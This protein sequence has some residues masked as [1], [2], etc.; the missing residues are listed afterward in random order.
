MSSG[1]SLD[2]TSIGISTLSANLGLSLDLLADVIRNPA[3][4]P[5]EVD[6]SGAQ[7]LA[8][9]K[10]NFRIRAL[11]QVVSCRRSFG[12]RAHPYAVPGSGSGDMAVVKALTPAQ[13]SAFHDRWLRPEKARIFVV[14]GYDAQ[15]ARSIA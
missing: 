8:G 4:A 14:G 3:F 9:I 10:A 7:Q 13:L 2:R 11:L 15:N 12:A 5:A 1:A 6:Q